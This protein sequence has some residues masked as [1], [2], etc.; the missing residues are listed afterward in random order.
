MKTKHLLWLSAVI[1]VA[2]MPATALAGPGGMIAKAVVHSFWGKVGLAL[3]VIFFMPL[4]LL[5]MIREKLAERRS[6]RD[7]RFM[8]QHAAVFDWL[9][10]KE[11][12]L[13][14]FYR[15][16]RAWSVTDIVEAQAWMTSWYWQNQQVAHLQRW[17]RDGLVNICHVQKISSIRPLLFA[18]RNDGAA[19]EGSRLVLSIT[20]M[21]QD[22]LQTVAGSVVEGDKEFKSVETIWSFV[23]QEGQWVVANIEDGNLSFLY[24]KM[25]KDL[26]EIATTLKTTR[27]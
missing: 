23:L 12:A 8:A 26:P 16:H 11:R 21:M 19:H 7:L 13:D 27:A 18:H 6:L 17:Q 1:V 15:V 3:L 22:Y 5:V 24:A 9:N 2:A 25:T 10:T 20:A 14:C 4:I